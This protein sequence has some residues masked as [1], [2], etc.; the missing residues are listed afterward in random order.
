MEELKIKDGK[1]VLGILEIIG[2][3]DN[4]NDSMKA[5]LQVKGKKLSQLDAEGI[6]DLAFSVGQNLRQYFVSIGIEL[7]EPVFESMKQ[8]AT[9]D[10]K[11][12]FSEGNGKWDPE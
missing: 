1:P 10:I 11:R 5:F 4:V 6:E 8:G 9:N 12:N 2:M 3:I 7:P